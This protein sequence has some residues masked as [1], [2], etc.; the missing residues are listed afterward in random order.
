MTGVLDKFKGALIGLAAGDA[1]GVPLEF[2]PPGSFEPVSHMQ[3]GGVFGLNPGEW[4]D[5][6]SM[7]LCLAHS[8]TAKKGFDAKDQAESYLRWYKEG[9]LSCKGVCFDIGV[10]TRQALMEFEKTG[11]PFSGPDHPHSA[12]NGSIMRLAPVPML[13]YRC[14]ETAIEKSGESSKITHRTREA[15]DGCRL[16]GGIIAGA[17]SGI[18]KETLLSSMYC[19]VNV[20]DYWNKNPLCDSITQIAE[21]SYKWKNPPEIKGSGYVVKSLEAALWAFY[22]TNTF[23]DGCLKAVNLG[24]DADTTGAVYGQIAG[25]YY[26]LNNIPKKWTQKIAQIELIEKYAEELFALSQS[27]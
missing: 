26:G 6:T 5:D 4:T 24:D 1:L 7:A 27:L 25:A 11:N 9:F 8:L 14:P 10:T 15:V 3:G 13:Y 18:D 23:E 20:K 16:M 22:N 21:G 17:L 19:P 12:G 2:Q